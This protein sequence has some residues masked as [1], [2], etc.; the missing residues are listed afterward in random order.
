MKWTN[1]EPVTAHD[2]EFGWK[3]LLNPDTAAEYAY[4]GYA[5]KNGEKYNNGECSADE[6]GVKA[7][8]DY[9]LVVTLEN[10]TAYF[11]KS[12]SFYSFYPVNQK[13][14]EEF[15]DKY[16]TEADM[17]VTNGA[18]TMKEWKHQSEIVLEK[19]PYFYNADKVEIQ[20][21]VMPMLKD[22]S[23]TLNA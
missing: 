15:G 6:V 18:F 9:E 8:G 20:K 10:P 14:Y 1:G 7:N 5:L 21:I 13:A 3:T 23:T 4:F 12:L 2:F 17:I 19:N 16:A 11:L 22:S